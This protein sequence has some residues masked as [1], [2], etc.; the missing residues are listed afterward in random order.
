[1]PTPIVESYL[2]LADRDLP[3]P[4][5]RTL[6]GLPAYAGRLSAADIQSVSALDA[7]LVVLSACQSGLGKYEYGEGYLG[8]A[9][10][11]L[12]AGARAVVLSLWPVDDASTALLM[13]ARVPA[14]NT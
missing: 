3:D 13:V 4:L 1:M 8:F 11:L 12:A 9:Q 14:S 7:D 6:A 5:A 2:A 10:A